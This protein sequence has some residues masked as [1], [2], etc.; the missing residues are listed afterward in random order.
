MKQKS[1]KQNVILL[2]FSAIMTHAS[3]TPADRERLGISDTLI[4]LSVGL[5]NV[6]DLIEDIDQALLAAVSI[7]LL[8]KSA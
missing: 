5:E 4:R 7:W 1:T 2:V 6:S 3:V 8:I